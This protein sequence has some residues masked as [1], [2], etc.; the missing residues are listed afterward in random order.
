MMKLAITFCLL[1]AALHGG[2]RA[3]TGAG[4]VPA[5]P[6][7]STDPNMYTDTSMSQSGSL[8]ISQVIDNGNKLVLSDSTTY[9]INP[10]DSNKVAGWLGAA[11]VTVS[12]SSNPTYP[13]S[14]TN[15]WTGTTVSA[16]KMGDMSSQPS[17]NQQQM[18]MDQQRQQQLQQQQMMDQQKQMMNQQKQMTDQQR[19][20][21]MNQPSKPSGY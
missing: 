20:Q 15:N 18:M 2:A 4:S 17:T 16:Q 21:M 19:Q 8:T 7:M 14:I 1:G 3:S 5:D 12:P 10:S 9:L 6:S 13:Y 11:D